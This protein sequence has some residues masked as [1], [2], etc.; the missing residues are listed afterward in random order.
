[1]K[2]SLYLSY[3]GQVQAFVKE[4]SR[5]SSNF[6]LSFNGLAI[7]G[8]DPESG[9]ISLKSYQPADEIGYHIAHWLSSSTCVSTELVASSRIRMH[10]SASTGDDFRY[11]RD[12]FIGM[13][14]GLVQASIS[15]KMY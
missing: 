13:Q 11:L 3:I 15:M 7:H 10:G 12:F 6:Y 1:L 5:V 8:I 9:K 14:A 4:A 2:K